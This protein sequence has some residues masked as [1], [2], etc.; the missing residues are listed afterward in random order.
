MSWEDTAIE[1]AKVVGPYGTMLG[2]TLYGGY[3]V[4]TKLLDK[5]DSNYQARIEEIKEERDYFKQELEEC[6]AGQ[7]RQCGSFEDLAKGQEAIIEKIGDL[8]KK[9]EGI[10]G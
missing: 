6:H 8:E 7:D 9:V 3:K 2:F 5:F 1:I 4:G 10:E